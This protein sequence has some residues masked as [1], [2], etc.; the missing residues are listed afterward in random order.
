MTF[1]AEFKPQIALIVVDMQKYYLSSES[2]YCKYFNQLSPGCLDYIQHRCKNITTPNIKLLHNFFHANNLPVIFIKL[3]GKDPERRDL[4]PFF[5]EINMKGVSTGYDDIYPL[6]TDFF[7]EIIDELPP[8]KEDTV[9]TKTTFSAFTS[10][11]FHEFLISRGISTLVFTGL[12]TSQ[13]VETTA[14]DASDRGFS[15][16]MI[17][18]SQADYDEQTHASSLYSSK[19][20]CGGFV[21]DTHGFLHELSAEIIENSDNPDKFISICKS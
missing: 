2:S 13:C 6:E 20:V 19:G 14:R 3:A 4:H 15:V 12:A 5:R 9:I 21:I 16:I 17:E 18:D 10:T 7:S 8:F 1:F 11:S